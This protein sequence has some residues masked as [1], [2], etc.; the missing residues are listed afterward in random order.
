VGDYRCRNI[1]SQYE[2]ASDVRCYNIGVNSIRTDA[3]QLGP[4]SV[5]QCCKAILSYRV[6]DKYWCETRVLNDTI[7]GNWAT[8][9]VNVGASLKIDRFLQ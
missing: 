8:G 9:P 6:A 1:A 5:T 2:S 3:T 7:Y 4:Y